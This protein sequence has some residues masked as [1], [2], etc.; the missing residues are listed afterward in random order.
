MLFLTA[1][2]VAGAFGCRSHP[3]SNSG[4][5]AYRNQAVETEIG[6]W[7]IDDFSGPNSDSTDWR[8][9]KIDKP[10]EII[11]E[12]VFENQLTEAAVGLYDKYGMTVA[13]DYK[14]ASDS[15]RLTVKGAVPAGLNFVKVAAGKRRFR[16]NYN[17][18]IKM[19]K[20]MYVPPRPF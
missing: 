18:R 2:L 3:E 13:E 20:S 17:L 4:E 15:A 8:S 9:F 6:T 12:V 16:S 11:I 7:V 10:A 5:D 19:G 14:R 1:L